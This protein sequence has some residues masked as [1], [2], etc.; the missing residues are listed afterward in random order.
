MGDITPCQCGCVA[1]YLKLKADRQS[2][3][4]LAKEYSKKQTLLKKTKYGP[5]NAKNFI[6]SFFPL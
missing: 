5:F 2:E 4:D 6:S 1:R 3:D